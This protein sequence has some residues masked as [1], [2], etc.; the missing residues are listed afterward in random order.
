MNDKLIHFRHGNHKGVFHYDLFDGDFVALSEVHTKK[1][2]YIKEK[3]ALDLTFDIDEDTYDIMAVDVI[4]DPDYVQKVYD[5]F[6]KTNNA[7]FT[8]GIEG[9]CVL[10]FHK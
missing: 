1:I 3:G 9:L 2:D 7:W 4:E 6:L 10:K 8:D 5:H